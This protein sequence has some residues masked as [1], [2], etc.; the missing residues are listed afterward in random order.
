MCST[1]FLPHML[2]CIL[3]K[4]LLFVSSKQST[5]SHMF[6][7]RQGLWQTAL[8]AT[9]IKCMTKSCPVF[10]FYHLSSG[11]VQLLQSNF[12]LSVSL[13]GQP[14]FGRFAVAPKTFLLHR[15]N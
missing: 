15:K 5:F 1:G 12:L 10:R 2:F 8:K 13:G 4:S 9:L 6:D 3:T 7:V 11:S 14:F